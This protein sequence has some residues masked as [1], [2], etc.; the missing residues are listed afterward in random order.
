LSYFIKQ[1]SLGKQATSNVNTSVQFP[2]LQLL[3]G[4]LTIES[5]IDVNCTSASAAY[6][7]SIIQ[8][9]QQGHGFECSDDVPPPPPHKP[10]LTTTR[11][12]AL[13]LGLGIPTVLALIFAVDYVWGQHRRWTAISNVQHKDT[14]V[15]EVEL[16]N[17]ET[18]STARTMTVKHSESEPVN[19]AAGGGDH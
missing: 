8:P 4:S 11:K 2:A 1:P 5:D 7:R 18:S 14:P 10:W 17:E 6:N 13:G 19:V 16:R 9:S 12:L 15:E 3:N